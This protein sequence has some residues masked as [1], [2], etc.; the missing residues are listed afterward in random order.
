M[1]TTIVDLDLRPML[2][3]G[4]EPFDKIM[5]TVAALGPGQG[6]RLFATFKPTPL[7]RVLESKG[8]VHEAKELDEGEW[9][10]LFRPSKAAVA[11]GNASAVLPTDNSVWP[12]PV[13]HL[14]NRDLDPPEPMVRILAAT[15]AMKEG[16][17]LSTLLCREPMFLLAELA[18]RGHHWRGAFE[19]D[20]TTYKILVRVG[21]RQGAAA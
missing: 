12:E 5:E 11:D 15:E 1:M 16:D 7:L 3:A 17:V 20:G 2:R 4:G 8:F 14:D 18:K 21:A 6:L 13:Q 9:E 10:V 19:P